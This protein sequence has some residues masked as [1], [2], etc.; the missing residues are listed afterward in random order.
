MV[1]MPKAP[2]KTGRFQVRTSEI[3]WF[4]VLCITFVGCVWVLSSATQQAQSTRPVPESATKKTPIVAATVANSAAQ[5]QEW[6]G[7][8]RRRTAPAQ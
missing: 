7:R 4:V 5:T 1:I 2:I 3:V 6:L 8:D